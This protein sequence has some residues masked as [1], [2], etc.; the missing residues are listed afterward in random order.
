MGKQTLRTI[1]IFSEVP[2]LRVD[3]RGLRM[4]IAALDAHYQPANRGALSIAFVAHERLAQMH[5]EFCGDATPTDIITFPAGPANAPE[6]GEFGELCISP[7][8]AVEYAKKHGGKAEDELRRY[9]VHGYLHLL[10]FDD[11][12]PALKR[13]MRREEARGLKLTEGI[14]PVFRMEHI[15]LAKRAS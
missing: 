4:L 2:S 14:R 8:A 5:A 10:G 13:K 7:Q 11:L 3:K 6:A 1:T 9:V 15:P 12:K